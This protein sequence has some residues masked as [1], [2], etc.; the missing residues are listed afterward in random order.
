MEDTPLKI[1]LAGAMKGIKE[2]NMPAFLLAAKNLRAAGHIVWS[3]VEEDIRNGIDPTKVDITKWPK[4]F[5]ELMAL[6]LP[7]VCL[8]DAVAVLP[9][10]EHSL[11][12]NLEIHVARTCKIPVLDATTLEPMLKPNMW[13]I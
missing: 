10:W 4:P 6:D 12:V 3:P 1:Y 8:A 11:G 7:Q 5:N 2:F 13:G 9:N